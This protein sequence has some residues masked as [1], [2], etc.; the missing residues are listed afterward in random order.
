MIFC[1]MTGTSHV[2]GVGVIQ[3]L[4]GGE[5]MGISGIDGLTIG[6]RDTP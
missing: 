5:L 1:A 6:C 3:V 2:D 4:N